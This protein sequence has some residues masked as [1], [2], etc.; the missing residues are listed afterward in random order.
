MIP[1]KEGEQRSSEAG[2]DRQ[3]ERAT[4]RLQSNLRLIHC[5]LGRSVLASALDAGA[6]SLPDAVKNHRCGLKRISDREQAP[7]HARVGLSF[8]ELAQHRWSPIP[9]YG[10]CR[11]DAFSESRRIGNHDPAHWGGE[12]VERKQSV[13]T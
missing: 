12:G 9:S 10:Q 8:G 6:G 7:R 5:A 13:S 2:A 1:G 3:S 11:H 4:R